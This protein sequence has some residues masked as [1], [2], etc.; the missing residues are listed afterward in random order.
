MDVSDFCQ[1]LNHTIDLL[2]ICNPNN[3]TSSAISVS[4]LKTI[5]QTCQ[6]LDIFVMIDETYIEFQRSALSALSL[7]TIT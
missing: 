6:K 4:D 1:N 7:I 3:P 5:V 2:I